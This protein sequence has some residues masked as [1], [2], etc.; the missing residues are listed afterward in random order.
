VRKLK[1]QLEAFCHKAMCNWSGEADLNELRNM[2]QDLRVE[3]ETRN[4]SDQQLEHN[5]QM[6]IRSYSEYL[7]L[8]LELVQQWLSHSVKTGCDS[9]HS[10]ILHHRIITE[11]THMS[12]KQSERALG[13]CPDA[14][15]VAQR[16]AEMD[17]LC[18]RIVHLESEKRQMHD[19]LEQVRSAV[20]ADVVDEYRRVRE[21]LLEKEWA[22][23]QLQAA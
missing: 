5:R 21:D 2:V 9:F 10:Y 18:T 12:V 6:L 17:Q 3:S 22:A 4:N 13:I 8:A 16:Q 14:R 1:S 15:R 7:D 19:R 23:D 11:S 20:S